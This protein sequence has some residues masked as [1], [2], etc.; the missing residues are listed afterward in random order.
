M[1]VNWNR[2]KYFKPDELRCKCGCGLVLM[3]MD[4]MRTLDVIRAKVGQAFSINSG[5]RC[6]EYNK[7]IGGAEGVHPS[8]KAV[9]IKVTSH[10]FLHALDA[11]AKKRRRGIRGIGLKMSGPWPGRFVHLDKVPRDYLEP[12]TIARWTY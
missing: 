9:D 5:F 12:G 2:I 8:G 11:Q 7:R 3:D 1:D 4:F 10:E 6:E